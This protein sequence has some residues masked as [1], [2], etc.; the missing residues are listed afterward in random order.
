[1]ALLWSAAFLRVL[2]ALLL[3]AR[4]AQTRE[5]E[6]MRIREKRY[7]RLLDSL[8]DADRSMITEM[9][10][11]GMSAVHIK[12]QLGLEKSED[13]VLQVIEALEDKARREVARRPRSRATSSSSSRQPTV[14]ARSNART[15]PDEHRRKVRQ[16][17]AKQR[18]TSV[19]GGL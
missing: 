18:A 17:K 8:S 4:V 16:R 14:K 11:Q 15:L 5:G 6:S 2:E 19:R 13:Y 7:K 1:M 12:E 9:R 3:L 10:T